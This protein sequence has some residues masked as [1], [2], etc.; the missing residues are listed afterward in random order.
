V[1]GDY[2][3]SVYFRL[4]DGSVHVRSLKRGNRDL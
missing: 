4:S 3:R 1:G 2:G